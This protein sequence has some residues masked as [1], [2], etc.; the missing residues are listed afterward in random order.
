MITMLSENFSE[1][2]LGVEAAEQRVKDNA[3]WL[4]ANVLEPLR[5][6][7]G[8]IGVTSGYRP[9]EHNAEV[10]GRAGSFHLYEGDHCAADVYGYK[11]GPVALF[12]WLRLESA[13]PFDRVIL[14]SRDGAPTVVHIQ[15]FAGDRSKRCR[16]AFVGVTGACECYREVEC[17]S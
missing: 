17:R 2:E 5:A 9:P 10:G 15:A 7:F 13:L 8:P 1:R 4:C 14:E 6:Q 12:D 16:L 11:A 3:A